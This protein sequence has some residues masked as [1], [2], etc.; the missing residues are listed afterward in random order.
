MDKAI[1]RFLEYVKIDTQSDESSSTVPSA[2]KE[3][4]LTKL[5]LKQVKEMGIE[6]YI[7]E[8][9]ILYGRLDGEEGSEPIGLNA[10]V[11]TASEESGKDVKPQYIEG[12]DGENNQAKRLLFPRPK[13]IPHPLLPYR[14]GSHRHQRRH[15]FRGR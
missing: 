10:H 3:L 2:A 8:F 5:L 7:D 15:P 12:Y 1:E 6:A 4:N 13:G 14:R 9:G 11:D